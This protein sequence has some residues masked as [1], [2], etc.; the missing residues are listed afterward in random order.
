M[1]L[2]VRRRGFQASRDHG[3]RVNKDMSGW[4]MLKGPGVSEAGVKPLISI[5]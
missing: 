5:V 1:W 4:P 2:L 3:V